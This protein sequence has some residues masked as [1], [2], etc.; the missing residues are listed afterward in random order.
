MDG[1]ALTVTQDLN[2]EHPVER[3]EVCDLYMLAQTV[4]KVVHRPDG[5][6]GNCAVVIV[7]YDNNGE[8]AF[9]LVPLVEDS[10]VD[11]ALGLLERKEYEPELL[12]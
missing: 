2:A 4:L 10:L 12:I 3:A 9:V 7:M 11:R 5:A 8:F 1:T 6:G